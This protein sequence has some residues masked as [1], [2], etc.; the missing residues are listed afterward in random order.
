MTARSANT[1]LENITR[2]LARTSLPRLPPALGFEGHEEYMQQVSLWHKWIVWELEDPLVLKDE[3]INAF[4]QRILFAYKQAAMTLRFWPEV[5]VEAAEWCFINGLD[6]EGNDFLDQGISANPENCLLA[7]KKA[8]RLELVPPTQEGELG[9]VERGRS[10]RMPYD[11]LL[12]TL[13]NLIKKLKTREAA[14]VARIEQTTIA[15]D[16]DAVLP[17][18]DEDDDDEDTPAQQPVTS[19]KTRQLDA[20]KRAYAMQ[21]QLLQRTVS[22]VWIAL[23]RAMR[24]VQGKGKVGAAVGGSRQ[25]LKDAKLRGRITS[26]VYVASALIEHHVYKD[27]AGTKIFERAAKLFPEDETF[28]LEYLKHLLSIGDTTSKLS[29]HTRCFC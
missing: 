3:D 13:Y 23:T 2:D 22:F 21:I 9:L 14:D 27:P 12:D 10:V 7:F 26:D 1:A 25:I 17:T 28:I 6:K 29:E 24:R 5:F 8:D 15:N 4:R 20:V 16:N 11:H 19:S 18:L